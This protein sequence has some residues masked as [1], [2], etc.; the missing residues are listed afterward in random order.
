M[1]VD[2]PYPR[3]SAIE[4]VGIHAVLGFTV[5][6]VPFL[7]AVGVGQNEN[8][9][10]ARFVMTAAAIFPVLGLIVCIYLG[11]K[12]ATNHHAQLVLNALG[13]PGTL[14]VLLLALSK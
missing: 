4:R 11:W 7:N 2:C 8:L 3:L 6:I 5:L 10:S 14:L 9:A 12:D 13:L 1:G